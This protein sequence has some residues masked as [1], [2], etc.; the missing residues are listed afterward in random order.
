VDFL[1][2]A[3]SPEG[4]AIVDPYVKAHK[5]AAPEAAW[6][7]LLEA[8]AKTLKPVIITCGSLSTNEISAAVRLF[9][10][11]R[12]AGEICLLYGEPDYPSRDHN[13]FRMGE[14]SKFNVPVGLSD[15]SLDH[16]YTP[17][18]ARVH[19]NAQ[20]I[21]KHAQLVTGEFA[22]S[23]VSIGKEGLTKLCAAL[24][25]EDPGEVGSSREAYRTQ[26]KRRLIATKRIEVGEKFEYGENYG[27]Y[28]SKVVDTKALPPYAYRDLNRA[29]ARE[30]I[31]LGEGIGPK[32]VRW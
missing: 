6:P 13:L 10:E 25:S 21:E 32:D 9:M 20:V 15:H 4:V 23:C 12:D 1:C 14:L 19:H 7:Q 17:L 18:S 16:I 2:S 26:Y 24:R 31:M 30:V 29:V 11:G 8:V 22:D 28:R 3:F 27:A 5:V